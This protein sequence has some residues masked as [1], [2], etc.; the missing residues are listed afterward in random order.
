MNKSQ[1]VAQ[2]LVHREFD[3]ELNKS[4]LGNEKFA[5]YSRRDQSRVH[6]Q[7]SKIIISYYVIKLSI[8]IEFTSL[9]KLLR[10]RC[11]ST[12]TISL[13]CS[14]TITSFISDTVQSFSG[15]GAGAAAVSAFKSLGLVAQPPIILSLN[16]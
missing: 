8:Y 13:F 11:L 1:I 3:Q 15:A 10:D 6:F 5:V 14:T 7:D 16:F 9:N 12:S 4:N 2:R